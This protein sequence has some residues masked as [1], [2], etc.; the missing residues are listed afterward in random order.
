MRGPFPG[1]DER[2]ILWYNIPN[3]RQGARVRA[4]L[5]YLQEGLTYVV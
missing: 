4:A 1:F 2:P 3:A 5:S